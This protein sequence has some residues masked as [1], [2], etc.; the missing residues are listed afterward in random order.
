MTTPTPSSPKTP[1]NEKLDEQ[2]Q[3]LC[4]CGKESKLVTFRNLKNKWPHC[5][6]CG[7]A[8]RVVKNADAHVSTPD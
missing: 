1:V 7:R 6:Q 4:E 5:K 8:M 2:V 3:A